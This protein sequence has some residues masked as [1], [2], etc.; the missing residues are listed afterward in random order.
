MGYENER[1]MIRKEE[2]NLG[3]SLMIGAILGTIAGIMFKNIILGFSLS[4]I[5]GIFIGSI[6]NIINRNE[7]I[8]K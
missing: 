5:L 4:S 1:V 7:K 3:L 2:K 6:I 8:G